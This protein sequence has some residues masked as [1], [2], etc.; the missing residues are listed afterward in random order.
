MYNGPDA[1]TGASS[2][3]RAGNAPQDK[4]LKSV[5]AERRKS[6]ENNKVGDQSLYIKPFSI[7]L[8]SLKYEYCSLVKKTFR[9][10]S[11]LLC[12]LG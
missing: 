8:V 12:S 1:Q 5:L 11:N 10:T 2:S 3:R 9:F 7:Q 4:M 6:I